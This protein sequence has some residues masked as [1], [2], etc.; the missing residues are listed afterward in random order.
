MSLF[1]YS[2]ITRSTRVDTL[3]STTVTN[4]PMERKKTGDP[5]MPPLHPGLRLVEIRRSTIKTLQLDERND[6]AFIGCSL[7]CN[8]SALSWNDPAGLVLGHADVRVIRLCLRCRQENQCRVQPRSLMREPDEFL[9]DPLSLV[10]LVHGQVGQVG[11]EG[12]IGD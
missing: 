6:T 1:L 2:L 5:V 7:T 4:S 10:F 9:A 11:A 12:E 8:Q 3:F